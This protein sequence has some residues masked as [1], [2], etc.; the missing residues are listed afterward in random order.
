MA[1]Q[2]FSASSIGCVRQGEDQH[3]PAGRFGAATGLVAFSLAIGALVIGAP[4]GTAAANPGATAQEVARASGTTA[5]PLVWIGA[6]VQVLAF[7]F[8]FAF[9]HVPGNVRLEVR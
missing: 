2:Q 7:L 4:T 1:T 3:L 6:F 9:L 8:L 5:T